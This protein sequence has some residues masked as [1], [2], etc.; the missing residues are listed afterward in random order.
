MNLVVLCTMT[1][2]PYLTLNIFAML[3]IAVNKKAIIKIISTDLDKLSF[4][5][6]ISFRLRPLFVNNTIGFKNM[7]TS[8]MVKSDLHEI[9][10]L[11][12]FSSLSVNP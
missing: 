8:K 3:N 1:S 9:I 7:T 6:W 12:L 11:L 10:F 5:W 2:F 4:K